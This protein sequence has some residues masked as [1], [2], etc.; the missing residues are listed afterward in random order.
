MSGRTWCG[1]FRCCRDANHDGACEEDI[2]MLDPEEFERLK[3]Y[4]RN[5]HT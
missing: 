5:D 2:T 4:D 1:R 3:D